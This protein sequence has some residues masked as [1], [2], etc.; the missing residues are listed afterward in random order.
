MIES[1]GNQLIQLYQKAE[2]R[3]KENNAM[4]K[5]EDEEYENDEEDLEVVKE[6]NNNQYDL[7]ITIAETFGYF[8]KTHPQL[9]G[10]LVSVLFNTVPSAL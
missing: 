7:M 9:C 6:E 5:Q 2:E 3:I 8:F 10:N 4:T 1:L